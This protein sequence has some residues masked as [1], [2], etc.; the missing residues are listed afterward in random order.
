MAMT[1]AVG[2]TLQLNVEFKKPV[3][4]GRTYVVNAKIDNRVDRKV[5]ASGVLEDVSGKE[6][7]EIGRAHV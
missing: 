1:A 5:T 3:H 7:F 6:V 4:P 2:P